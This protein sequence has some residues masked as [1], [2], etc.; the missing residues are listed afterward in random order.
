MPSELP[1]LEVRDRREKEEWYR[2]EVIPQSTDDRPRCDGIAQDATNHGDRDCTESQPI[3]RT[4]VPELLSWA[5][6]ENVSGS[7]GRNDL[8]RLAGG[9]GSAIARRL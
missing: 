9:S 6:G 8:A 2:P 7:D 1:V 4:D 3:H 5:D